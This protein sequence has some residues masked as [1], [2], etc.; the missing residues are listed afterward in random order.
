MGRA[1]E[2]VDPNVSCSKVQLVSF[3]KVTQGLYI[4]ALIAL[5]ELSE[6]HMREVAYHAEVLAEL[7]FRLGRDELRYV[8]WKGL[9]GSLQTSAI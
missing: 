7:I 2:A 5:K 6:S 1:F 8:S 3:E 9:V 4:L